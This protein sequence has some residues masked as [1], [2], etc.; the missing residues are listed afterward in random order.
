MQKAKKNFDQSTNETSIVWF[1]E[2]F[3]KASE[4]IENVEYDHKNKKKTLQEIIKS[5]L[6]IIRHVALTVI[7]ISPMQ[8]SDEML[9][10]LIYKEEKNE[11]FED[12]L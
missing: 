10:W 4:E 12:I 1:K 8:A 2:D 6:E 9:F 3:S 7:A 11:C 5:Y